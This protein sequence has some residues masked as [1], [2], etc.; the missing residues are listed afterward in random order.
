MDDQNITVV[1]VNQDFA[2]FITIYCLFSLI[3]KTS[4][5]T[6]VVSSNPF[7]PQSQKILYDICAKITENVA[8]IEEEEEN[9]NNSCMMQITGGDR[10]FKGPGYGP[11]P[12]SEPIKNIT[13]LI[14][15]LI[16]AAIHRKNSIMKFHHALINMEKTIIDIL[17]CY[18]ISFLKQLIEHGSITNYKYL[19][20]QCIKACH[21]E[22]IQF[23][24]DS[25]VIKNN[26]VA[27]LP[28]I[29]SGR[30][31]RLIR[32]IRKIQPIDIGS[33]VETNENDRLKSIF[34]FKGRNYIRKYKLICDNIAAAI[35]KCLNDG[36]G[37]WLTTIE[38]ILPPFY[39]I[40]DIVMIEGVKWNHC[41]II[42]CSKLRHLTSGGIH[43]GRKTCKQFNI[44]KNFIKKMKIK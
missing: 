8:F 38:D 11:V 13:L 20:E 39:R 6:T 15:L 5:T 1:S 43:M 17:L 22:L 3:R 37:K 9:N 16:Q 4:D 14:V 23:L 12:K 27:I 10:F 21:Y 19:C 25:G 2:E 28:Y 18:N 33:E 30:N 34:Y 31:Y 36:D 42:F 32:L 29:I 7:H 41:L 35:L 24:I 44:L 40:I 26:Y